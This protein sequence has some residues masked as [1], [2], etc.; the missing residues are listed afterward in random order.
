M[1]LVEL[2]WPAFVNEA[3]DYR[4]FCNYR[5]TE[6]PAGDGSAR[7]SAWIRD[8]LAELSLLQQRMRAYD[9]HYNDG[10]RPGPIF[11]VSG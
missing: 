2:A 3:E 7:R 9:S 4:D 10:S 6:H 8:R 5:D 11:R 1:L